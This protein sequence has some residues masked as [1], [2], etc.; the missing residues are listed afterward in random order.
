MRWCPI[1]QV[2][3]SYAII[4]EAW[5]CAAAWRPKTRSSPCPIR[6]VSRPPEDYPLGSQMRVGPGWSLS[7][8]AEANAGSPAGSPRGPMTGPMPE[9]SRVVSR[10]QSVGPAYGVARAMTR[11]RWPPVHTGHPYCSW[12]A[13]G[14]CFGAFGFLRQPWDWLRQVASTGLASESG[15]A[16]TCDYAVG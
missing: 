1:A 5:L 10:D 13:S 8:A 7:P 15:E 14:A 6:S 4:G 3:V 11:T 2:I 16:R 9:G 12:L